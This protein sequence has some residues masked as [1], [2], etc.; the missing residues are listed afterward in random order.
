MVNWP[1]K[2][3]FFFTHQRP[4]LFTTSQ[5]VN[6]A[7]RESSVPWWYLLYKTVIF[8][9]MLSNYIA[10]LALD[11]TPDYFI[12]YL[13]NQGLTILLTYQ[14]LDFGLTAWAWYEARTN[15]SH[16]TSMTPIHK[17][18]WFFHALSTPLALVITIVYWSALYDGEGNDYWN[19][20]VHGLNSVIVFMDLMIGAKP[21]RAFHFYPALAYGLLYVLFSLIYYAAGGTNEDGDRFIYSILDWSKPGLAIAFVIGGAVLF[22]II[23]PVVYGLFRFDCLFSVH[24]C[25]FFISLLSYF[26]ASNFHV[27]RM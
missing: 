24:A 7:D 9:F 25:L 15:G 26:Q 10:N 6:D 14:I 1:A 8:L 17:L 22:A 12:I 19:V 20:Y 16:S 5:W 21:W 23:Y 13:T 27:Q 2:S 11:Q 4:S 18:V 3:K